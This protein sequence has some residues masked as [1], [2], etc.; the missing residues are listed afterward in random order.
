VKATCKEVK[1]LQSPLLLLSHEVSSRQSLLSD[2]SDSVE[3]IVGIGGVS[4][5]A[6]L[7]GQSVVSVHQLRELGSRRGCLRTCRPGTSPG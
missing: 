3:G 7:V 6:S 5:T 2:A 1:D 4:A